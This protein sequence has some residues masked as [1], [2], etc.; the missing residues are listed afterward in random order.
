MDDVGCN[1]DRV[2][3]HLSG[4]LGGMSASSPRCEPAVLV[5]DVDEGSSMGVYRIQVTSGGKLNRKGQCD[6]YA[7]VQ[8]VQFVQHCYLLYY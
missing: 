5:R 6:G 3:K 1:G 7:V 8:C 2:S 4:T